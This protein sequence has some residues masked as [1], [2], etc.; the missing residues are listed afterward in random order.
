MGLKETDC[1]NYIVLIEK[2]LETIR[3]DGMVIETSN[4]KNLCYRIQL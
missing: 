3:F 2:Y 1:N 4:R